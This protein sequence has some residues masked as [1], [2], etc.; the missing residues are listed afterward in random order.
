MLNHCPQRFRE[1]PSDLNKFAFEA[2]LRNFLVFSFVWIAVCYLKLAVRACEDKRTERVLACSA[3][4]VHE[5]SHG[6]KSA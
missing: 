4:H 1:D 3:Q 2:F 6:M 5:L